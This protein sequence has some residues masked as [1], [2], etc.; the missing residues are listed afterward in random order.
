MKLL[1]ADDSLVMR[2][3]IQ[4]GLQ[5]ILPMATFIEAET[6]AEAVEM[7]KSESPDLILMDW[8]MPEMLGIE[9][10]ELIRASGNEVPILMVTTEC[11][12]PRMHAAIALGANGYL[13]KP[14]TANTL[15][16]TVKGLLERVLA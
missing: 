8:N 10:L 3:Y 16:E 12:V 2:R 13:M 1:I 7:A 6:G 15:A 9:A 11:E 5:E 4:K 14:F